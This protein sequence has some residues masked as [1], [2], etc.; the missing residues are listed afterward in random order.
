LLDYAATLA[1]S[2]GAG[3]GAPAGAARPAPTSEALARLTPD[4][5][6]LVAAVALATA[7]FEPAREAADP[8]ASRATR[9]KAA[10]ATA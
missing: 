4:L 1:G 5:R 6:K 10:D 3:H 9:S 8:A 7:R 2:L